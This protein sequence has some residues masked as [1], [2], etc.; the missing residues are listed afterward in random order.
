VDDLRVE[1]D[2]VQAPGVARKPG[3]SAATTSPWLIQTI[4][5]TSPSRPAN[6][7]AEASTVTSV[8]PYSRAG[9]GRTSPPRRP[10]R[11]CMP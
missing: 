5:G 2:R 7:A 1:L 9:P 11:S 4:S 3:G 8:R 6:S 10:P